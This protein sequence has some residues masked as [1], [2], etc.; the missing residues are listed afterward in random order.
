MILRNLPHL[1]AYPDRMG[2][3]ISDLHK[4]MREHFPRCF[5]GVHLLPPFPSNADGGFS[6]L[7]HREIDPRYGEALRAAVA[8]GVEVVAVRAR[9][10]PRAITFDG[11]LP[12]E[13]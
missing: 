1:I 11:I 10:S 6:P 3:S 9:V 7:T 13:L 8:S 2:S 4:V 12:V 5:G